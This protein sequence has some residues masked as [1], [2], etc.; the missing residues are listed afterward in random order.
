MTT[1]VITLDRVATPRR[2]PEAGREPRHRSDPLP[3]SQLPFCQE[4]WASSWLGPTAAAT[5]K[6]LPE[7]TYVAT[8]LSELQNKLWEAADQLRANS[9]L[10]HPSTPRRCWGSSS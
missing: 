10:R 9:G 7:R 1:R 5:V 2:G 3:L 4:G 8:D 6:R